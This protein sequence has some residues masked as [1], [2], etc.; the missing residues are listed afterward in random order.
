VIATN[1][2]RRRRIASAAK[3]TPGLLVA[4]S[5]FRTHHFNRFGLYELKDPVP[6]PDQVRHPGLTTQLTGAV[7]FYARILTLGLEELSPSESPWGADPAF[8]GRGTPARA[9]R[10]RAVL[11]LK[12][13][14]RLCGEG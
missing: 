3:L 9:Q 14:Q 10:Q 5:P 2:S 13:R 6:M 7:L 1:V 12:M 11:A 8:C 4:C